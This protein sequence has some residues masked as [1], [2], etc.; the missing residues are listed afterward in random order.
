[1][2][3]K[4]TSFN[5]N[6]TEA[7]RLASKYKRII[8]KKMKEESKKEVPIPEEQKSEEPKQDNTPKENKLGIWPYAK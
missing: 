6:M 2:Q 4:A 5:Q 7:R 1:M 8:Q 3:L